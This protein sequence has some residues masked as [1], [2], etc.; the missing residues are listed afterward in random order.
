[1]GRA[2]SNHSMHLTTKS[3]ALLAFVIA[4]APGLQRVES[5]ERAEFAATRGRVARLPAPTSSGF[6]RV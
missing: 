1:M 3:I 4:A 2:D 5:A 6:P